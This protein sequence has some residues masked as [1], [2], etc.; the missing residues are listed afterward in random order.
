M[1]FGF[2]VY[3]MRLATCGGEGFEFRSESWVLGINGALT[4][5][6]ILFCIV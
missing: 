2:R 1:A 4:M 5:A 3:Y 6:Q